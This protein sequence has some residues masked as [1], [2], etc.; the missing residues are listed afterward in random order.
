VGTAWGP[1]AGAAV[2]AEVEPVVEG[3]GQRVHPAILAAESREAA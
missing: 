1:A 2:E 3:G